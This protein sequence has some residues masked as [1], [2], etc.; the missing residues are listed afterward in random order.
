MIIIKTHRREIKVELFGNTSCCVCVCVCVRVCVCV[1]VCGG[2]GGRRGRDELH[3]RTAMKL[4][5]SA[6]YLIPV[7]SDC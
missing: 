7:S 1:S 6:M 5:S 3:W 2:G 4:Y